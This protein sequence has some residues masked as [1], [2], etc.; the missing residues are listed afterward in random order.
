MTR[1]M[2]NAAF[3]ERYLND[4]VTTAS[5]GKLLVMLYD[6]LV[7]DLVRA[8]EA[9]RS[10]EREAA[11]VQL[12]H[13]QEILIE[14]Q[15]SLDLAAWPEG[16]GLAQLYAFLLTELVT[17]NVRGDVDKTVSCREIIEPLRDAWRVAAATTA[18]TAAQVG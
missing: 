9:L 17:A 5:P 2:T 1:I 4:S 8:E 15:T 18:A 11:S 7:L 16:K 12:L 14:L 3:R 10:G 13:A 6:R